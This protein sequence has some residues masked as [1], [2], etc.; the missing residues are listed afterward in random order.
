LAFTM[1]PSPPPDIPSNKMAV[2]AAFHWLAKM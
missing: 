2:T 1:L